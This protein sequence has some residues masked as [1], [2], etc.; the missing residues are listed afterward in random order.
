MKKIIALLLAAATLCAILTGC[1]MQSDSPT[2]A[3]TEANP[4]TTTSASESATT[5]VLPAGNGNV[6]LPD[7]MPDKPESDISL[8]PDEQP[9]D[10][11]EVI[12]H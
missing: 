9:G 5:H 2:T 11:N 7:E 4:Q 6:A 1:D 10:R 3:S 8:P 12:D